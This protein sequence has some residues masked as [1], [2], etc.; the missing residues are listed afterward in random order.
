MKFGKRNPILSVCFLILL[1][2][3]RCETHLRHTGTIHCKRE[4]ILGHES[5]D[6]PA[7]LERNTVQCSNLEIFFYPFFLKKAQ[8]LHE[9]SV[10]H[11][12]YS[13]RN[14]WGSR[15]CS[16]SAAPSG[17]VPPPLLPPHSTAL[18]EIDTEGNF[19]IFY[20]EEPSL[21]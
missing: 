4:P 8:R 5:A 1:L 11:Q 18:S 9:M 17:N 2:L 14:A 7:Y 15:H 10:K 6:L 16:G 12:I 13:P 20:C 21:R 3:K 19:L